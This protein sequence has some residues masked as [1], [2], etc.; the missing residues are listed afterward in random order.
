MGTSLLVTHV[1]AHAHT[2]ST[3][4]FEVSRVFSENT[5]PPPDWLQTGR[6][7]GGFGRFD[8][9]GQ[10]HTEGLDV[11]HSRAHSHTI[12]GTPVQARAHSCRSSCWSASSLLRATH[13]HLCRSPVVH[14]LLICK[15]HR[16]DNRNGSC[17]KKQREEFSFVVS[18]LSFPRAPISVNSRFGIFHMY[19]QH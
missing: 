4:G 9:R 13:L 15:R 3:A 8:A 16:G 1:G 6:R 17:E 11:T 5:T 2:H 19:F 18:V 10:I 12:Q 7:A 14:N